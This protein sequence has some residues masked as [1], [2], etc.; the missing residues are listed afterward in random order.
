MQDRS[1]LLHTSVDSCKSWKIKI[2]IRRKVMHRSKRILA[3]IILCLVV[4]VSIS[5]FAEKKRSL[6]FID[7]MKFK[8]IRSTVISEDG[9][10]VAYSAVPDRG[11][12][13]VCV[14]LLKGKRVYK[15]ERGTG[16]VISRNSKW[17]AAGV[18][19]KAVEIEK[20]KKKPKNGMVLLNTE[21][22]EIIQFDRVKEFVFSNDSRWLAFHNY[23]KEK[24][25]EEDQES[26]NDQTKS[27]KD[28]NRKNEVG[29]PL[30]LYNLDTGVKKSVPFV[31]SFAFDSTS[32]YLAYSISDSSGDQNGLYIID[33]FNN[34]TA[35]DVVDF[36]KNGS[37]TNLSWNNR[38]RS[39]AYILTV[40]SRNGEKSSS[41]LYIWDP[42]D[43]KYIGA[44]SDEDIPDDWFI[45][46]KNDLVWSKDG[47]RLFFGLKPE[48]ERWEEA[49]EKDKEKE[50]DIFDIDRILKKRG[51]DVWHWNDPLIIPNQKKQWKSRR[52]RFYR[53][54]YHLD[55]G[56][57]VQLA[58]EK[59]AYVQIS[60]NPRFV[61]G[62][63]DLPYQKL[64]TWDGRYRDYYLVSLKDGSRRLIAKK[65]YGRIS[66]SPGG[67]YIVYYYDKHW[68]LYDTAT[69]DVK[70]LTKNLNVP[71]YNED[72]DYPQA[73]PSYGIAGWTEGD[74]SVLIYDK[75]DIWQF[76]TETG[77]PL[78][79]T[80]G[81]GRK[82]KYVFRIQR[83]DRE[84][85]YFKKNEVVLLSAYHDLKK[86]TSFY[87]AEIGTPG[88]VRLLEEKKKF[89]F[90]TKAKKSSEILYTRESYKEFPDLWISDMSFKS[91]KKITNINPQ[92][93]DFAWG[94]AELVEWLSDDGIPLQGVL[95][96]PGN[97]QKGKRYPVLVY[98]YRF[99]SQRLYD[100]NQMVINHRPN[101]PFYASNGYA[102]FLPD[103]RFR[104]GTPGPSA[105]KCI[106]PGVKKLIDMGIAD[107]KAIALH[108]HSWSGYQTAFV[109][110]QTDIFACAIAGAPVSNMT[111]AYSGIRWGSGLARQFQ[112]EKSQSRIGASLWEARELYI[113][114]SP[115][116]FADRI[117]TPL[118]IMFGD[119]DG[120]V[121]W[122]Q[123]IELYLAMRRLGKDCI[124]LEY[125]GE[126][127]HP[128]KYANKLDYS[129]RMKEYLDHYCKGTPAP[130]WIKS[131]VP[132]RG[133]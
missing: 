123:G 112:Y 91:R 90:I 16:P 89:R 67:K 108:G 53:A 23:K 79:L 87:S 58:D 9:K 97:Y 113:E 101:F 100:F 82:N 8:S 121:P 54:V 33:L 4:S 47:E 39:L 103:I 117:N 28:N 76:N 73:V 95:I 64:I 52:D 122:Y 116:F 120:A 126:P 81:K 93:K 19:P 74:E 6:T 130:Q 59:M 71:F 70:N 56:T 57:A 65:L 68:Y 128:Q 44:V 30:I 20:S 133:R 83:I 22:G 13:E 35:V 11:D 125:R 10:I 34:K 98:F 127:H 21:T 27:E 38:N 42:D 129:I 94:S 18:L 2:T 45:P 25:E 85:P 43:E 31:S 77:E 48:T 114:N 80:D 46:E 1:H 110:T 109:I 118:L 107:P 51:V 106:V 66:M 111:S 78:N 99:F 131:G 75:Y 102:I 104:V 24:K 3:F 86:H 63:S 50:I 49:E 15:I 92:I 36:Q 84:R 26:D 115:V 29:S 62:S 41:S 72:H 132:Y 96:R 37:F 88:V 32:H 60:H 12:G 17:V 55:S 61:L 119:D 69:G 40:K 124:F 105:T 7:I 14:H 5:A